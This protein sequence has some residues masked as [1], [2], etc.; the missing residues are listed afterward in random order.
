MRLRE[1]KDGAVYPDEI[2]AHLSFAVFRV[3]TKNIKSQNSGMCVLT[4]SNYLM[5][6]NNPKDRKITV[7]NVLMDERLGGPQMRVLQVAKSLKQ[8]QIETIVCLPNGES[9]F[10]QLLENEGIRYHQL[11]LKRL[12]FLDLCT[13]GGKFENCA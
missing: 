13:L 6:I 8:Y 9:R 11:N 12:K 3:L 5:A 1:W 4:M 10:V 7:L 2:G